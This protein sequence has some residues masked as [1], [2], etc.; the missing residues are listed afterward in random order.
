MQR[1]A[2][3]V[4]VV[5]GA[6]SGIGLATVERLVSE[7]ARVIAA[8]IQVEKGQALESRFAGSVAFMA[9]DVT[10]DAEVE[11]AIA[12]A[13]QRFGRLDLVF[14]NAGVGGSMGTIEQTP[15]EAMRRTLDLLLVSVMAGTRAA[16]PIMRRQGAGAIVNTASVAGL[17]AGYG[18][19]A[20]STA[21][22]AV[23]HFSR[24]AAAELGSAG[25]RVNS[26]SP[27]MIATSIF[28]ASFG[29]AR[30]VAD[31]LAALIAEK[32]GG[33]Q[34]I[35]RAGRP[36]DIAAMVAFLGSDEG[37]F[38]TGANLLVDGGLTVGPRN[39]WD[40]NAPNPFLEALGIEPEQAQAMAEAMR[41]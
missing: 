22:A 21:K 10:R 19:L 29:M 8:D 3:K 5:T 6:A 7:G 18:P 23:I 20:Y 2:D 37:A 11:A 26:I 41:G 40:A 39:A 34:P 14:N 38:V 33:V 9:C 35:A 12:A 31:Q 36:E 16:V 13:D 25:I 32:G 4:A 28:G 1:Y 27:G 24:C 17:Q 15:V 30:P